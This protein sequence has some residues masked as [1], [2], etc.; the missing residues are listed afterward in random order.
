[1]RFCL[2]RKNVDEK[3]LMT[4]QILQT[5]WPHSAWHQTNQK[6]AMRKCRSLGY[7]LKSR[8]ESAPYLGYVVYVLVWF[9]SPILFSW[10]ILGLKWLE[11]WTTMIWLKSSSFNCFNLAKLY[12][13]SDCFSTIVMTVH[14]L[15]R[16]ARLGGSRFQE[17]FLVTNPGIYGF[18]APP[19]R[20]NGPFLLYAKFDLQ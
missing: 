8:L 13:Q 20:I 2:L 3:C 14:A 17:V 6:P 19:A 5:Q 9:N 12:Q 15:K 4:E 1:M 16:W 7:I 11:K 18:L 10:K